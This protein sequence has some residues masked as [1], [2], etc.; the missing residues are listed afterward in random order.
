[1]RREISDFRSSLKSIHSWILL[2]GAAFGLGA[3]FP[4]WLS[5]TASVRVSGIPHLVLNVLF[6][7]LAVRQLKH[8][9]TSSTEPAI[10][11]QWLGSGLVLGGLAIFY[12]YHPAVTP[13]AFS[14]M[15]I[16]V[17]GVLSYQSLQFLRRQWFA[18]ALLAVSLHPNLERVARHLWSLFVPPQAL[19]EFMAWG[20]SWLLRA[21]GQPASSES[22]FVVLPT[23]SVKVAPGCDGFEMTFVIAI[24]AVIIGIAFRVR[25]R[26]T[27]QLIAIGI[28]LALTLNIFRIAVMVLAVVYWGKDSF[29]FWHGAIG[30]QVFSGI[31]F[32]I[33]YYAIQPILNL[34][35]KE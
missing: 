34:K 3:Y 27:I 25:S 12:S 23:G 14:C 11:D 21:I 6:I 31:L 26:W 19:S 15:I 16:L 17:G 35:T 29:E 30:G 33:Y 5:L 18:I 22:Q 32:T 28:M 20:G 4:T 1:M 2:L 9:R 8:D 13:Q 10:E 7:G 24:A